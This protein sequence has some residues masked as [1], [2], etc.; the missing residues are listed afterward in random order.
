MKSVITNGAERIGIP[1]AFMVTQIN[2]QTFYPDPVG[3]VS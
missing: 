3:A 1:V 2:Q